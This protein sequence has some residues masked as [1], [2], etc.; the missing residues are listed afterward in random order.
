[1]TFSIYRKGFKGQTKLVA[2][3][4]TL[5]EAIELA[6]SEADKPANKGFSSYSVL[7]RNLKCVWTPEMDNRI[8]QERLEQE[9]D[10]H[11]NIHVYFGAFGYV[12]PRK[13]N[14]AYEEFVANN[15]FDPEKLAALQPTISQIDS[16]EITFTQLP[17]GEDK[18]LIRAFAKVVNRTNTWIREKS[19]ATFGG[20]GAKKGTPTKSNFDWEHDGIAMN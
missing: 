7:D 17:E 20:S 3:K 11:E 12:F 9:K 16:E 6:K 19:E 5:V 4:N 14:P 8:E 15:G 10:T 13:A 1:M 18:E 2:T